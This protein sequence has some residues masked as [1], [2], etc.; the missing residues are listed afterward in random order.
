MINSLI[1]NL[2]YIAIGIP[3]IY[4]DIRFFLI[5]FLIVSLL[6]FDY[7]RKLVR[8]NNYSNEMKILTIARKL[9]ISKNEIKST[10]EKEKE[11]M[12]PKD[13]AALE[14]DFKHIYNIE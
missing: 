8:V 2:L 13:Y 14:R 3:L 4:F 5:F 12:S 10:F 9:N 6:F 7:L 11:R 1:S